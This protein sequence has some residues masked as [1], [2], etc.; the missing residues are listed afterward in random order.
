MLDSNRMTKVLRWIIVGA[1]IFMVVTYAAYFLKF[2]GILSETQGD[3]GQFGDY[4]G[5]TLNPLLSF[6]SLIALVFTVSL[7][8]QQLENSRLALD[9]SKAELEATRE[10]MRRSADAQREVAAAAH[11]QAEYA[12]ISTQLSALSAALSVTSELLSQAQGA[13]VL[14]PPGYAGRLLQRKEELATAIQRITDQ[15]LS[16]KNANS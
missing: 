2:H 11:S 9:N 4:L 1:L 8:T 16:N 7:Q 15:L 5:G 12:N 10:E 13:G 3:W 6:L 14:S